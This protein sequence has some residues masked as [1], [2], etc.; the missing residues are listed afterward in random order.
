MLSVWGGEGSRKGVIEP[1]AE[2][3]TALVLPPGR[4]ALTAQA[5][6]PAAFH[7][8][9]TELGDQGG[10]RIHFGFLQTQELPVILLLPAQSLSLGRRPTQ[11]ARQPAGERQ[12]RPAAA[13]PLPGLVSL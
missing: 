4:Y 1:T 6:Q 12:T 2:S 3:G 8:D 10:E 5:E 13:C 9:P 11:A 7:L